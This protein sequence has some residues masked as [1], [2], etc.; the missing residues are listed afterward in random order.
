IQSG[1]AGRGSQFGATDYVNPRFT[2]QIRDSETGVDFFNARYYGSALGRFTSPDPANIGAD[3][4][5]PQT[6]NGYSYVRNN[7]MIYT[8]PSGMQIQYQAGCWYDVTTEVVS[9]SVNG[10]PNAGS[11]VNYNTHLL[12]CS[13]LTGTLTWLEGFNLINGLLT[14]PSSQSGNQ[15][16]QPAQAQQPPKNGIKT[17]NCAGYTAS[18]SILPQTKAQT[19]E[20]G[21]FIEKGS[22]GTYS[23]TPPLAG[24]RT[25]LPN[26]YDQYNS[27]VQSLSKGVSVAGWYHSHPVP[28]PTYP[29]AEAFSGQDLSVSHYINAPGFVVTPSGKVLRLDPGPPAVTTRVPSN[30]CQGG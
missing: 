1:V 6:W 27:L 2:G 18:R 14:P 22:N 13:F 12:G 20:F 26:F 24:N 5:D 16:Q 15:T 21:G 10:I 25:S 30:V 4:T 29:S 9:S 3:M 28:P 11:A 17:L 7:P 19:I 8:D 23:Y